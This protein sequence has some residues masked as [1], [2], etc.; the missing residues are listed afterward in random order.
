MMRAFL[1][2]RSMVNQKTLCIVPV[3]LLSVTLIFE[4]QLHVIYAGNNNISLGNQINPVA[5]RN[6]PGTN[7]STLKISTD[8]PTYVPAE[9]VII[10]IKNNLRL[11]LE[12]PDSLLGLNIENAKTGQKAGLVAAQVISELKPLES[13]TFLWDQKDTNA[14]QVEPGIYKAQTSSLRTTANTTFTIKP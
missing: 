1:Q 12:F 10:T 4:S 6:T 2:L 7:D 8:K 3:L 13:K 5:T 14:N 9:K 11:P